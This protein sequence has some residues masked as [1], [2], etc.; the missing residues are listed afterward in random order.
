MKLNQPSLFDSEP[1]ASPMPPPPPAKTTTSLQQPRPCAPGEFIYPRRPGICTLELKFW[2][3]KTACRAGEC[4]IER[5]G[6]MIHIW[7]DNAQVYT[8]CL[9]HATQLDQFNQHFTE[10]T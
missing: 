1:E 2:T 6:R 5:A 8:Y 7:Q 3:G 10:T 9:D 4:E